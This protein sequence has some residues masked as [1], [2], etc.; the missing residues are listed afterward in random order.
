MRTGSKWRTSEEDIACPA[1]EWW[2]EEV[3]EQKGRDM[4]W[5]GSVALKAQ[6]GMGG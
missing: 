2:P 1:A 6:V 3:R 5:K 4:L